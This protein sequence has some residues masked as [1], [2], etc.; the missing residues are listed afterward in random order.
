MAEVIAIE[1]PEKPKLVFITSVFDQTQKDLFDAFYDALGDNFTLIIRHHA[2]YKPS[3]TRNVY[4]TPY[5]LE[6]STDASKCSEAIENAEVLLLAQP[7]FGEMKQYF[8][9]KIIIKVG[10]RFFKSP[11]DSLKEKVRRYLSCVVHYKAYEKYCPLY[12]AIGHYAVCDTKHYDL[13]SGRTYQFAYFS[14]LKNKIKE[15]GKHLSGRID[16]CW[17]GRLKTWKRPGLAVEICEQAINAGIDMHLTIYGDDS[18]EYQNIVD[19]I[20]ELELSDH[21]ILRTDALHDRVYDEISKHHFSL[22]TSDPSEGWGLTIED[23]MSQGVPCFATA[24]AG[25]ALDLI[26][27]NVNGFVF[28]GE[29]DIPKLISRLKELSDDEY[30][31]MCKSCIRFIKEDF[32]VDMIVKRII[33]VINSA[34]NGKYNVFTEGF[35][36]NIC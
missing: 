18:E 1:N 29:S 30:Q 31:K 32:D 34:N 4:N 9:K 17:I 25:A 28:N 20:D 14:S 5:S 3:A 15:N 10:E 35:L 16:V 7:T 24:C 2:G 12:F 6:Y 8:G 22:V 33:K 19:R 21:I 26:D 13:F 27:D 36:K 11:A 23:S